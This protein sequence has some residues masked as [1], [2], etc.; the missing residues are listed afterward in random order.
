VRKTARNH[1]ARAVKWKA[2]ACAGAGQSGVG[3]VGHVVLR[4][5]EQRGALV[6]A[7]HDLASGHHLGQEGAGLLA[8]D[9]QLGGH[10]AALHALQGVGQELVDARLDLGVLALGLG[11]LALTLALGSVALGDGRRQGFQL[12]QDFLGGVRPVTG[13]GV[14]VGVDG[15]DGELDSGNVSHLGHGIN[16][17][18]V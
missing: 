7:L 13:H 15:V 17:F 6:H 2:P 11:G 5:Q 16:P 10:V 1:R 14:H 4:Q 3:G 8:A 18:P 9:A 12:G